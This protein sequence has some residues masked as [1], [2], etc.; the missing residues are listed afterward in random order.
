[1]GGASVF[2]VHN[3]DHNISVIIETLTQY[4]SRTIMAQRYVPEI[5]KVTNVFC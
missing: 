3:A 4:G 2:R 5:C 1:M